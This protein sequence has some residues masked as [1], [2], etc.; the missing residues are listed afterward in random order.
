MPTFRTASNQVDVSGSDSKVVATTESGT[1]VDYSGNINLNGAPLFSPRQLLKHWTLLLTDAREDAAD[2]RS[3][4]G[5]GSN[6]HLRSLGRVA[7]YQAAILALTATTC[8]RNAVL[9]LEAALKTIDTAA[10]AGRILADAAKV[11][12]ERALAALRRTASVTWI[13]DEEG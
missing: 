10:P 2:Y 9:A 1:T 6:E 13:D 12:G 4:H 8:P 11:R 3:V 7:A 5:D